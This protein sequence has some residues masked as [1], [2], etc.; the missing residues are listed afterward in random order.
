LVTV[1]FGFWLLLWCLDG[2]VGIMNYDLFLEYLLYCLYYQ[3]SY[4]LGR[5]LFVLDSLI[6]VIQSTAVYVHNRPDSHHDDVT[7]GFIS[8]KPLNWDIV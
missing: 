4:V 8:S 3:L 1:T 2:W 7:I 5:M 6:A